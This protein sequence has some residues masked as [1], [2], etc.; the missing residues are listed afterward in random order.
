MLLMH[1]ATELA[2]KVKAKYIKK[3]LSSLRSYYINLGFERDV[4]KNPQLNRVV[5]RIKRLLPNAARRERTLI[6][7]EILNK[8]LNS[9]DL[10]TPQGQLLQAAFSLA[11]AAFL[12]TAE[13]TYEEDEL[14]NPNISSG[15]ITRACIQ[16]DPDGGFRLLSLPASKTDSFRLGL[17]IT[18]ACSPLNPHCAVILKA[19]Y[20][21]NTPMDPGS[22][23]FRRGGGAPF[24]RPCLIW[25]HLQTG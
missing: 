13:L 3:R 16:C 12:R 1:W 10:A 24:T 20:L 21:H 15:S 14:L 25:E 8:L 2:G 18:I 23:L 4:F 6:T 9:L 19:A 22:P 17:T 5:R 11:F 7:R